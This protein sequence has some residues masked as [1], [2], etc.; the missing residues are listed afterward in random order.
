[1][2]AT[3]SP[4]AVPPPH[5]REPPS[6]PASDAERAYDAALRKLTGLRTAAPQDV[7]SGFRGILDPLGKKPDIAALFDQG[8]TI[9]DPPDISH[10]GPD[11]APKKT[12]KNTKRI[13]TAMEDLHEVT[14]QLVQ[15]TAASLAL[16]EAQR[17]AAARQ[18]RFARRATW[19]SIAIATASLAAAVVAIVV[20]L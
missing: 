14:G 11:T 15:L 4:G 9:I 6:E 2:P 3:P 13:A 7:P 8:P 10:I 20:S 18:E 19:A 16:S 12:A 1:M 17:E 5:D